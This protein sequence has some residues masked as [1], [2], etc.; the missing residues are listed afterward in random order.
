MNV[1]AIAVERPATQEPS[2]AGCGEIR[3]SGSE[4][5]VESALPSTTTP[6]TLLFIESTFDFQGAFYS[7]EV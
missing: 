1:A 5:R 7:R 2:A 6:G 4:V 3:T